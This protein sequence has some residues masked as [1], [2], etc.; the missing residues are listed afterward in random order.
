ME[1]LKIEEVSKSYGEKLLLDKI[2]LTINKGDKIALI[3]KNGSGKSTLLRII[4][5][6]ES[7]EGE[8]ANVLLSKQ[9]RVGFLDQ[10]PDIKSGATIEEVFLNIDMPAIRALKAYKA[11]LVHPESKG[12]EEAVALMEDLKAWD[13]E[14]KGHEMLFRMKLTNLDQIADVLSGGQQKRL[15]L[16][17]IL[18]SEP[19]FLILDEPTNHL[20]IEMIEWL[21][22][23]LS[24][25]NIT[26]FMVTHDR[27]FL[28]RVC[29][30][31]IELDQ[32]NLFIYRGNYSDY[33]E[34]KEL[35]SQQEEVVHHKAKRLL[36][37][38]LEWMRRQ[39]KARGTKAKSR[40]EDYHK[41]DDKV[42]SISFDEAFTIELDS[43]RLGKKILE[44]YDV[45]KGYDGRILINEFWYKFKKGERVGISG[46]NG[47]G[48]TT[49]VNL[50]TG[51]IR[52]DSGKRVEGDTVE[53][54]YYTQD[55]LKLDEDKRIIDVIRDIADFIPLK[56]GLKLSAAA[57]LERFM[58]TREHQQVY[59]S[60]LSGGER[61][62]L[63]LLTIL[64]KNPNFLILDEP[65]N[66]L[67]ILTLN[68]LESYLLQFPGCLV[69]ISHDRF[70]MDKLVDHMFIFIGEEGQIQDFNGTYSEWKNQAKSA[71]NSKKQK[72]PIESIN[73]PEITE[74]VE[75][76]KLSY[77]EKQEIKKLER[78]IKK[79]EYRKSEIE[80]LFGSG[81]TDSEQITAL[82]KEL[83]EINNTID[84]YE[85]RW[86]ELSEFD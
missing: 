42:S 5:G 61:K 53:F 33:L 60:Q 47:S 29:N 75:D 10:E 68:V 24:T 1:Y 44:F 64:V 11:A 7:A 13:I 21:E 69:I 31:I 77:N 2:N 15:A 34:K 43:A 70:F 3:A 82:S 59:V 4:A 39:P 76:R 73:T 14:A 8:Q 78:A 52:P 41:L 27:Y 66:D 54:G 26:L 37:K 28:E 19:D 46:P 51:I 16:A 57:L 85:S 36:S 23:Y 20:D 56:K 81:L 65:T 72:E 79:L 17:R 84:E 83:G 80:T 86:L 6:L 71:R 25:S 45:S 38:E 30:E 18:L 35:R 62:R 50:I 55:G 40:I 63:H 48:K 67:D 32:G 49:L 22:S 74:V 12:L 9:V 58:F